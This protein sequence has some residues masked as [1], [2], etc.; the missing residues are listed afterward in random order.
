MLKDPLTHFLAV[1]VLVFVFAS[2]A[3]PP[4]PPDDVIVVDRA[5]ILEFVQYRSKAFEPNA[6]AALFDAMDESERE[7][8]IDDFIREEALHREAEALGLGTNDYVIRQ[9]MVQKVEFLAEAAVDNTP[10]SED[11]LR[12][13]YE[14]NRD[15]FFVPATATFTHVFLSADG[16]SAAELEDAATRMREQLRDASAGFNDAV[17]YGERFLFHTNYV[18]RNASYVE[19]QMG[20]A[21][22]AAVFD[23]ATP[24]DIWTGPYYSD[25]GAHIVFITRR[26][27]DETPPFDDIADRVD[28]AFMRE[29]RQ[30]DIDRALKAIVD[31]YEIDN[32]LAATSP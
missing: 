6:A 32:Q 2:I 9:R 19:N 13:F 26:T 10:A 23:D 27:P 15:S 11:E 12:R 31:G 17:R 24:L 14:Q 22:A 1:G 28:A 29:R 25:Y 3:N 4:E 7:K 18:D 8:I 16:R 30:A 21:I 20:G 5:S